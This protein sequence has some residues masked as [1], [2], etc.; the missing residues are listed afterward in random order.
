M[1][2]FIQPLN[3]GAF[4]ILQL[5]QIAVIIFF[6]NGPVHP[7]RVEHTTGIFVLV[8]N[9]ASGW[10]SSLFVGQDTFMNGK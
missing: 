10:M 3:S 4:T 7:T 9:V 2:D 1:W 5:C 6:V 8:Y